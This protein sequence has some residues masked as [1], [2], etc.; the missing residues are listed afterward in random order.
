LEPVGPLELPRVAEVRTRGSP[1]PVPAIAIR[2][3]RLEELLD[4]SPDH[5]VVLVRA[6]TGA[7]KTVLVAQWLRHR[8]ERSAWLTVDASYDDADLLLWHMISSAEQL[9]P[10][11]GRVASAPPAGPALD[12]GALRDVLGAAAQRSGTTVNMVLDGVDRVRG[13]RSRELV[14]RLLEHPPEAVRLVLITRAKPQLGLERVRM[15]GDLT[16]IG[17]GALRFRRSEIEALAATRDGGPA[18]ATQLEQV[19]LGW[20]AGLR[21]AE[22]EAVH[23]AS[24][25]GLR[26][27]DRFTSDYVRE[28]LIDGS[29][30]E[31]RTF[32]R[33]TCWLPVLTA[34]LCA[35]IAG[36]SSVSPLAPA[37]MEAL[38]VFPV[39]SQP[40]AFRY[41][42][43]LTKV[44]QQEYRRRDPHVAA[45]AL[46]RAAEAC[47]RT[48]EL[49]TA[50]ELFLLAGRV[51]EGADACADLAST[52]EA[53]L[54]QVGELFRRQ[55][56]LVPTS[57]R[58]L[59]WRIRAA[60]AE[61]RID[62]ASSLLRQV[63]LAPE[64]DAPATTSDVRNLVMARAAVAEHMGD[65]R[66][67]L[68]CAD[69]LVRTGTRPTSSSFVALRTQCWRVRAHLWTGDMAR[70]R[71]ALAGVEALGA[72]AS[73]DAAVH[74]DMARAW[75]AWF[76]GDITLVTEAL[77]QAEARGAV[78][79]AAEL[80]LLTGA[81]H[82]ERNRLGAAVAH[83]GEAATHV[84]NV[85]AA[86]A[87]SELARC[88]RAAGATIEG[89][90][91]V[92]PARSSCP[93]LPAAVDAHL[94]MTETLLR[95]DHG[96][97]GGAYAVVR[98][99]QPCVDARLLAVRVALRQAPGRA[100][101][102]LESVGAQSPRQAVEKL[103]LR[104]QLP[105]LEP[106]EVSSALERA[107][108]EGEP[109]G[110]VRIFLDEGPEV[111]RRIPELALESSDRSL[112]R[113]AALA[114]QEVAL[115][116][117]PASAP[118]VEQLTTRELAVLRMLPLRMSNRE[119][120]AQMYISVNTLKTHVRA[121]Y[122]KLGVPHRSAAVR[123]AKALELV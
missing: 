72:R 80:A 102:L 47:R 89:L 110:L 104:A 73:A 38:P 55:P 30:P 13:Q 122:R 79:D 107:V 26:E 39:A 83:L 114:C 69:E 68:A 93:G 24:L 94:R 51:D 109:R 46:C 56:E 20:A 41:P 103:L 45:G 48:G 95:L 119:M 59:T 64:D 105:E 33:V 19:T 81:V 40:G 18:D 61:G 62:E 106:T 108:A 28:E 67:M 115:A 2:R 54:R 29:S 84:H 10:D 36:S 9:A 87:A 98:A 49:V 12:D 8:D 92:I 44:L 120:A 32:L 82:R 116:P 117:A 70:A 4:A 11:V 118:P 52:G 75:L 16:E 43:I 14:A 77:A 111:C 57:P 60:V 86:L 90:E 97:V 76:N 99:A 65:V 112:G 78:V 21:L 3:P 71:A 34:P 5:R 74:L 1:P 100:A 85:V 7:G 63:D 22:L 113:I 101:E 96:D 53:A 35:T 37:D 27:P 123:R 6:P 25:I 58:W 91:L 31:L 66:G 121:I 42:P 17:P 50:I 23:D 88:H 15:R